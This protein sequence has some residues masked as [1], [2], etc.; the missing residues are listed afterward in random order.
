MKFEISSSPV[1][2]VIVTQPL[3]SVPAFVMNILEPSI[4]HSPSSARAVVRVAPASE[5][6]S[7][8]VRPKAAS[9]LARGQP[10]QPLG[11]LLLVAEE[12]DRHRAERGVR[13]DGDRE[14]GV[15]ARQLLDAERVGERVAARAAVGLGDGH[16]EQAEL[17]RLTQLGEREAAVRVEF[18]GDGAT[19]PSAKPRTVSRNSRCSSER[20]RSTLGTIPAAYDA[21]RGRLLARAL[22][23]RDRPRRAADRGRRRARRAPRADPARA[24]SRADRGRLPSG[25]ALRR[26][27]RDRSAHHARPRAGRARGHARLA[28][29]LGGRAHARARARGRR[30]SSG[31]PAARTRRCSPTCRPRAR[32]AASSIA[33][34]CR[35]IA[36][37]SAAPMRASSVVAWPTPAWAAQ[38]YPDLAP[39]RRRRRARRRPPAASPASATTIRRTAGG[40]MRSASPSAPRA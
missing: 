34:A 18:L 10:R 5:P 3:I 37:R 29:A 2:A 36:A 35:P 32:R 22:R 25:R 20:S 11:A 4:T 17:C 15:D 12:H 16:A 28:P 13:R 14:G 1:R 24:R 33:P 26:R 19:T 30:A 9:A 39:R 21:R 31:S 40:G 27:A 6:A 23:R 38:V 7:G 8:S